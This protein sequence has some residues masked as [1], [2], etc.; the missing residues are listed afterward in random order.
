MYVII[1]FSQYTHPYVLSAALPPPPP[2]PPVPEL[3]GKCRQGMC[4]KNS[5]TTQTLTPTHTHLPPHTHPAHNSHE[6]TLGGEHTERLT[7]ASVG[8]HCARL[9]GGGGRAAVKRHGRSIHIAEAIQS[10]LSSRHA[11]STEY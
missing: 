7:S 11:Y 4:V 9:M 10:S 6:V 5:A 8:T 3:F 2:R 1:T